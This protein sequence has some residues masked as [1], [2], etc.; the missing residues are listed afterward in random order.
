MWLFGDV[1][2]PFCHD[3]NSIDNLIANIGFSNHYNKAEIYTTIANQTY[4]SSENM[5]ITN[6]KIS[7]NVQI[8][9]ND[10]IV[11]HPRAYGIPFEMYAG[12]SGFVFFTKH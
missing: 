1:D 3:R 8:K 5:D 9:I 4:T 7:L 11:M 2:I 10:E 6:N 12:T